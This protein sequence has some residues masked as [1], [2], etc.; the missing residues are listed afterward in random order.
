MSVLLIVLSALAILIGF[1]VMSEAT[2][3]VGII[4]IAGVLAIWARIAQAGE[5]H[6]KLMAKMESMAPAV[7]EAL[8]E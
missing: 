4:G 7:K 6:K 5:N 3:G 8:S 2:T 1:L